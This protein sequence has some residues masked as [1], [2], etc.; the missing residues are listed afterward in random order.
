[1]FSKEYNKNFFSRFNGNNI[2]IQKPEK[3]TVWLGG[4]VGYVS[5][6]SVYPLLGYQK[7]VK[8]VSH[9]MKKTVHEGWKKHANDVRNGVSPHMLKCTEYQG[10]VYEFGRCKIAIHKKAE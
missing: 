10:N 7:G 3:D 8:T 4:G 6:T 5:K 9:I 2:R 1:M